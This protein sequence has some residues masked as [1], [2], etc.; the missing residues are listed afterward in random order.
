MSYFGVFVIP[1]LY[2]FIS[3]VEIHCLEK[4]VSLILKYT[5]TE[6]IMSLERKL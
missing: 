5:I 1:L 4:I 3:T 6:D 2:S